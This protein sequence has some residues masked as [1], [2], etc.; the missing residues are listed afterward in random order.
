M[1]R[2]SSLA[3]RF[4]LTVV[5]SSIDAQLRRETKGHIDMATLEVFAEGLSFPEGPVVMEDGSVIVVETEAG[6]LT[7][8]RSNRKETV[9]EP[10]GGPN[11]AAIG[12]DGALYVCNNGGSVH[13]GAERQQ[14]RIERI[15][16]STG[17]VERVYDHY[18]GVPLSAPNDLVF[19]HDGN[20][21]FTDFGRIEES[22]KAYGALFCGTADGRNLTLI[23]G[24][25]LSYNGVGLSPDMKTV[26]VADTYSARIYA[27][28]RQ[29][30]AQ[31]P[32]L[33]ATVPGIVGLDS[34]AV[35]AA[36]NVCVA[37]L[38]EG[39]VATVTPAGDVVVKN[40]DDRLV[41]NIAFGGSDK[42]DAW[43]TFS[44]KGLLVKTSWSEPGLP[45]AYN[46]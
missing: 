12:P 18:C 28:D 10:G 46:A 23:K 42:Q 44:Q 40:L 38:F 17:R 21:W 33:V 30:I 37:V 2:H 15:D 1:K 24:R 26:Y 3:R 39:G 36:G 45:L 7:R 5:A 32:R 27:F 43:I 8:C 35:T 25:A 16:I 4:L 29:L 13:L 9:S 6:R 22:G 19:D 41:T 34:L 20:L 31:E 14:G 11:G